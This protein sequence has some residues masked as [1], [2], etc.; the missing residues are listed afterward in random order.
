MYVQSIKYFIGRY[1]LRKQYMI[2]N[3]KKYS[4]RFKFKVE[5]VVGRRIYKKGSYES[6]LSD[7]VNT[8]IKFG[9]GDIAIDVGA[10]I[11]WYSMLLDKK[12]PDDCQILAFEPDPLNSQLLTF[13]AHMN[14]AGKVVIIQKALS[15][16]NETKKLYRY[17]S[18]NLGRHSMLDINYEDYIYVETITLDDYL[19]SN[20]ID[21]SKVKFIKIDIEGYE[22]FALTGALKTLE[23]V[24]CL[25]SEFVP[26]YLKHGGVDP[27][28]LVNL[29]EGKGFKSNVLENGDIVPIAID[30]LLSRE[31]NDIIW[32]K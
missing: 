9:K 13:N 18:R 17:S 26:R 5:D 22:Y 24:D 12:M 2:A 20:N 15:D 14:G 25:I 7:F 8:K 31:S 28:L 10:N 3:A 30:D 27:V 29:L 6:E 19:E 16:K 1:I 11:G 4:N 23:S 21:I 32:L